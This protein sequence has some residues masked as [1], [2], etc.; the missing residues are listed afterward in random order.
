MN[1]LKKLLRVV[2]WLVIIFDTVVVAFVFFAVN[3]VSSSGQNAFKQAI[4]NWAKYPFNFAN[5]D[6]VF[7]WQ[8]ILMYLIPIL[9]L[10]FV[11]VKKEQKSPID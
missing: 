8:V 10:I 7:L 11:K 6:T 4:S 1:I 5:S 9:I 2:S 3:S